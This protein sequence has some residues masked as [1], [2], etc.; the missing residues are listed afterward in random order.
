MIRKYFE[1]KKLRPYKTC[2]M[3]LDMR[4]R[5][6]RCCKTTEPAEGVHF[7]M[8]ETTFIKSNEFLTGASTHDCIQVDNENLPKAVRPGDDIA[9]EDGTLRAVVL[10][11]ELDSV[12]IQFK[13][14]GTLKQGNSVFI[15]G[16]RLAQL[17]ILQSTDKK[18]IIEVAVKNNFDYILVPNVT[19]VKDV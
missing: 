19:S 6:I 10:E 7:E 18:D 5:E 15:P 1:A 9:F 2:A 11:T 12:K 16:H 8:G 14:A 13:E 17:P 4:G 3:V